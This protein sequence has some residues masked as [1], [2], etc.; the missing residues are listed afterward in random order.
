MGKKRGKLNIFRPWLKTQ[1][2]MMNKVMVNP[3]NW[4]INME[5]WGRKER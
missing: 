4:K 5:F 1:D 2:K 3:I